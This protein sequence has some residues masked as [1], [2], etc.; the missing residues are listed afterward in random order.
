MF[1]APSVSLVCVVPS[2]NLLRFAEEGTSRSLSGAKRTWRD[3][4]KSVAND[5]S[6]PS[7]AKFAVMQTSPLG[8][9]E[10]GASTFE[11]YKCTTQLS[12]REGCREEAPDRRCCA[13]DTDRHLR[14][15]GRHGGEGACDG[16]GGSTRGQGRA[17]RPMA[18]ALLLSPS[19]VG[20]CVLWR[21]AVHG[22]ELAMGEGESRRHIHLAAHDFDI[23]AGFA[24]AGRLHR[25]IEFAERGH[26]SGEPVGA[27]KRLG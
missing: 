19:S 8:F 21:I 3:H 13:N 14:F 23:G 9:W 2:T 22:F 7:A 4:R 17:R 25:F 10:T 18:R 26:T 11:R 15:R 24:G 12:S 1:S 5:P 16:S 27:T 6:R 20:R